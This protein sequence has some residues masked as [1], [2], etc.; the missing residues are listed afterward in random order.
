MYG[1][2]Q[3]RRAIALLFCWFLSYF[4]LFFGH[5]LMQMPHTLPLPISWKCSFIYREHFSASKFRSPS[6]VGFSP[7]IAPAGQARIHAV[8]SPHPFSMTGFSLCRAYPSKWWQGVPC[9]QIPR[10]RTVRFCLRIQVPTKQPPSCGAKYRSRGCS[11]QGFGLP[12]SAG[13]KSPAF[14]VLGSNGR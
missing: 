8:Q 9:S 1:M 6:V 11:C 12:Q 14:Q 4:N 13:R 5:I 10:I 3:K 2:N 7:K